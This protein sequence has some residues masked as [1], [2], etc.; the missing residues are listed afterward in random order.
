MKSINNI[1]SNIIKKLRER[2][3]LGIL[4]CKNALIKSNGNINIAIINMKKS[5]KIK[6]IKNSNNTSNGVIITK[7]KNNTA[8]I[9]EINSQ[10]DF[11][12]K[13][14]K[15]IDFSNEVASTTLSK[16]IVH[17]DDLNYIFEKKI[18]LLISQFN[19][20]INIKRLKILKG[21]ELG[22]YLHNSRIGVVVSMENSNQEIRKKISMHIAASN[23]Q[24]LSPKDIP[25][26]FLEK[27]KKIQLDIAYK[28]SQNIELCKK[29]SSGRIKKFINEIS[30]IKQK[31]IFNLNISVEE[32]LKENNT[33][34]IHFIRFELGM[35]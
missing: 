33:N 24:Y 18:N 12:A 25:N 11:V 6:S 15:F 27:E 3:G 19:E 4:Q 9:L 31:F 26:I 28:I 34:V 35:I 13:N 23:P 20:Y 16:N 17:L 32:F 5:G 29:I 1:N 7:I 21:N 8:I 22:T 30:L 2:T 10:T 14:K